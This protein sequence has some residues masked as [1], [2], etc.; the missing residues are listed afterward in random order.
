MDKTELFNKTIK[1]AERLKKAIALAFP[2]HYIDK[3]DAELSDLWD[4]LE[5]RNLMDEFADFALA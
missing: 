2:G 5:N 1:A 3:L 4:E